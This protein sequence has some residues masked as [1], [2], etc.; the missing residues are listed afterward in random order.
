MHQI[1]VVMIIF[2]AWCPLWGF[3][4]RMG[5]FRAFCTAAEHD[6]GM[7]PTLELGSLFLTLR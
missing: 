6:G 4:E 5:S 2:G 1:E 7:I 3:Y